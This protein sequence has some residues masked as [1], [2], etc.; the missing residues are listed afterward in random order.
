VVEVNCEFKYSGVGE[1]FVMGAAAASLALAAIL[2][3]PEHIR[4]ALYLAVIAEAGLSIRRLQGPVGLC[5]DERG[6]L[7][8]QFRDGRRQPG[9]VRPGSFVSPWLTIVRWRPAG[10]RF[11]R[12]LVLWP[13]MLPADAMRRVRV[14]LR[15]GNPGRT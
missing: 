12:T 1:A 15:W 6:G 5:L 8:V 14:I 3:L 7:S 10:A 11:D 2:P 9:S 13:D 4:V